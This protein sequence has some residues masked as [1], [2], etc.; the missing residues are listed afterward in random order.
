MVCGRFIRQGA[1]RGFA[2]GAWS[3]RRA[4]GQAFYGVSGGT[5]GDGLFML[6]QKR[7]GFSRTL[8]WEFPR[9]KKTKPGCFA[10]LE[11][12]SGSFWQSLGGARFD[13]HNADI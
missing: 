1:G 2:A 3:A 12:L 8:V 9:Q 4:R 10:M 11:K 5:G 13:Q 6:S 7:F